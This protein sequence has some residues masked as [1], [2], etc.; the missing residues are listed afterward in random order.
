M[1]GASFKIK[2]DLMLKGEDHCFCRNCLSEKFF[3]S[4]KLVKA[5]IVDQISYSDH[6][7]YSENDFLI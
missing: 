2:D 5:N 6:H 3:N 1:I 4:L 7:I